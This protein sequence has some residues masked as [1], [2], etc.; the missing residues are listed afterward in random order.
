MIDPTGVVSTVA[1]NG[2]AGS[3]GD[4]GAAIDAQLNI[5]WGVAVDTSGSLYIADV[6]NIRVRKVTGGVRCSISISPQASAVGS[7]GLSS[8]F[9]ATGPAG[10]TYSAAPNVT[11]IHVTAGGQG[12]G[13]GAVFY[14]VDGIGGGAVE[15][16]GSIRVATAGTSAYYRAYQAGSGCTLSLIPTSVSAPSSGQSGFIQLFQLPSLCSSYSAQSDSP[17]LTITG[18]A[19][20][21]GAA[22]VPYAIAANLSDQSRMGALTI[23]GQTV[24]VLQQGSLVKILSPAP[25]SVLPAGGVTFVW[26]T[27]GCGRISEAYGNR[28]RSTRFIQSAALRRRPA[29]LASSAPA[30][31]GF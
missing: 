15:R 18:A 24:S 27:S 12:N 28:L 17:W 30:S 7:G 6:A 21:G 19:I 29:T 8:S 23:N 13:S 26:S 14:T 9:S 16:T 5:P 22:G 31:S 20:Y 10:C 4:G 3:N 11:W 1:G 2:T 25:G